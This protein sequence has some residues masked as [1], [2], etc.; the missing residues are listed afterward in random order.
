MEKMAPLVIT[1][2]SMSLIAVAT[3]ETV[4]DPPQRSSGGGS[5]VVLITLVAESLAPLGGKEW[6][7]EALSCSY[8]REVI[9]RLF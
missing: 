4:T 3:V 6:E 8:E 2:L 9:F 5:N 7:V 1:A